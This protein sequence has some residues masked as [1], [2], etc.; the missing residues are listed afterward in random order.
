MR[1]PFLMLLAGLL[2][3]ARVHDAA[4]E[5]LPSGVVPD[6]YDLTF[7]VDLS[8]ARFETTET[9]RVRLAEPSRHIVLHALDLEF[10]EAAIE[11]QGIRQTATVTLDPASQTAT[12][13][14]PSD[15]PPGQAEIRVRLK[16][17]LGEQLRGFYLS[18][19]NGRRYAVTQFE[20]TDARR[21]FAA[22]DEPVYKATFGITLIL[23]QGDSGI[24]N[25]R[26]RSDTRGPSSGRHTIRFADTPR[27]ST[28]LVA[29]AVGNFQCLSATADR[30][31]VRVCSTP[32]K[33]DLGRVALD[34]AQQI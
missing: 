20:S 23:D 4:A 3:L 30:V 31:P 15:V 14:V 11:S 13:T 24:S 17:R 9:V 29:L 32:D 22:F 6:H 25:G 12:L 28:Y 21:A 10:R 27:M 5:R 1:A 2:V 19:A 16:G 8:R 34:A 7:D 26:L 18:R 33:R